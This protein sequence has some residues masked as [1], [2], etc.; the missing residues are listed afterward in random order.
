MGL[1]HEAI[2]CLMWLQHQERTNCPVGDQHGVFAVCVPQV[3]Y[4]VVIH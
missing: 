2:V 1:Q 4:D 3:V